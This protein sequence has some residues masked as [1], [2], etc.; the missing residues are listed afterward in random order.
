MKGKRL[1]FAFIISALIL[2]LLS[3]SAFAEEEPRSGICGDGAYW[4]VTANGELI[5]SG[6]GK[7]TNYS[8]TAPAPWD[9]LRNEI[10]S[11]TVE[12]GITLIGKYAF[13]DTAAVSVSLPSTLEEIGN[14]AFAE[15]KKLTSVSFP[16]SL[17]IIRG[18]AFYGCTSLKKVTVPETVEYVLEWAFGECTG[19]EEATVYSKYSFSSYSVFGG[20]TSL[21]KVRLRADL[22]RIP[23]GYFEGCSSLEDIIIPDTVVEIGGDAFSGCESLTRVVLPEGIECVRSHAFRDCSSLIYVVIPSGISRLENYAFGGCN[24]V[25]RHFFF[26]GSEA[27]WNSIDKYGGLCFNGPDELKAD[28]HFNY[29]GDGM[30]DVGGK[31]ECKVCSES[32]LKGEVLTYHR[33]HDWTHLDTPDSDGHTHYRSCYES[34][35]QKC[36]YTEYISEYRYSEWTTEKPSTCTDYG[37]QTRKCLDCGKKQEDRLP[38]TDHSFEFACSK[39]CSNPD[40]NFTREASCEYGEFICDEDVH[41]KECTHCKGRAEEESHTYINGTCLCGH[42]FLESQTSSEPVSSQTPSENNASS[43]IIVESEED[44]PSG[45]YADG[46][47]ADDPVSILL[48]AAFFTVALLAAVGIVLIIRKKL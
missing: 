24:T 3:V 36:G 15:N 42:T 5:I 21:K 38:L 47:I 32:F 37:R 17:T 1:L 28:V 39:K 19:L 6:Q 30:K 23:D 18:S 29:H 11:I 34:Y 22:E 20:C 25:V 2:C 7:M 10:D 14:H 12:E 9:R 45:G 13:T 27:Q 48:I 31:Y 43:E 33:F 8:K 41:Y 40:C 35:G 16:E 26:G 46:A 44:T 4:E